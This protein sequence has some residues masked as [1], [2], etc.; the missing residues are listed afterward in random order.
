MYC[1][2]ITQFL[3]TKLPYLL[4]CDK[5]DDFPVTQ[6]KQ[7][8][9]NNECNAR[10]LKKEMV[11]LSIK[12]SQFGNESSSLI[13][14]SSEEEAK[15]SLGGILK[16]SLSEIVSLSRDFAWLGTKHV[17]DSVSGAVPRA[18][19]AVYLERF[20]AETGRVSGKRNYLRK[21]SPKNQVIFCAVELV[22]D[23]AL[24]KK[25]HNRLIREALPGHDEVHRALPISLWF[26]EGLPLAPPYTNCGLI[27]VEPPSCGRVSLLFG[28]PNC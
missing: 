1:N 7:K 16:R 13:I 24:L 4:E 6:N 26:K 3:Y 15:V 10:W 5:R 11:S 23:W 18:L 25:P 20:S 12:E 19:S 8:N 28:H 21:W 9:E 2:F 22:W 27:D 14:V 17:H